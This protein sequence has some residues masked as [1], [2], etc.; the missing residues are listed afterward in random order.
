MTIGMSFGSEHMVNLN[1][2]EFSERPTSSLC[3]TPKPESCEGSCMIMAPWMV[4]LIIMIKHL[5]QT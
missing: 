2:G 1:L 4:T 3:E 5:V